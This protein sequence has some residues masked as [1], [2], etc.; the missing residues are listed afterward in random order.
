MR[1][2]DYTVAQRRGK[3]VLIRVPCGRP[4]TANGTLT[5]VL[6]GSIFVYC[7]FVETPLF[8]HSAR[9]LTDDEVRAAQMAIVANP[10]AGAAIRETHGARK[11]RV[12]MPGR[13]K[14]GGARII[15]LDNT[16]RCCQ[17]WLL[18]A[19]DK[20]LADDISNAGRKALAALIDAVKDS[21]CLAN[22]AARVGSQ[23]ST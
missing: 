11:L 5:T 14:S 7:T 18:L 3:S 23:L 9:F 21:P 6:L 1:C 12:R 4:R 8:S 19:Y 2:F 10:R 16:E 22:P 20:T 13:G 17:V 15:Y